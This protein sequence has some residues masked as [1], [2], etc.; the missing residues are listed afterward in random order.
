MVWWNYKDV[1]NMQKNQKQIQVKLLVNWLDLLLRS[2]ILNYFEFSSGLQELWISLC[3][4]LLPARSLQTHL[5][6]HKAA[7][8]I[9]VSLGF[10]LA[11][12]N[13]K[14]SLLANNFHGLKIPTVGFKNKEEICLTLACSTTH[15]LE[16]G[17]YLDGF[18]KHVY[19]P[20]SLKVSLSCLRYKKLDVD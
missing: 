3:L 13:V 12:R 10:T 7:Y 2:A 19:S 17:N 6:T 18:L 15:G 20:E 5:N 1:E 8:N 16:A 11:Y 14:L 9:H 4:G